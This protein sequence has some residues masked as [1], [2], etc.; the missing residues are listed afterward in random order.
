MG[1]SR[2]IEVNF[3]LPSVNIVHSS[4][5]KK[6]V[7]LCSKPNYTKQIVFNENLVIHLTVN[8]PVYVVACIPHI[9]E[10]L[11][12]DFHYNVMKKYKD[13]A[14]LLYTDTDFIVYDIRRHVSAFIGR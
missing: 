13:R 4:N 7:R 5:Y 8:K 14:K 10:L 9:S 12:Y 11:M 1:E 6:T 3:Y 2:R